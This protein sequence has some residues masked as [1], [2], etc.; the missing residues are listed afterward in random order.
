MINSI[1]GPI[2][3]KEVE[4][5]AFEHVLC[6]TR[7]S[8][9]TLKISLETLGELRRNPAASAA[10]MMLDS[11]VVAA[12][13]LRSMRGLVCDV[14][15]VDEH[16]NVAGLRR[17]A[18]LSGVKIAYGA[19]VS[20][21]ADFETAVATLKSELRTAG[22]ITVHLD[23][24]ALRAANVVSRDTGALV[25]VTLP[26]APDAAT[27]RARAETAVRFFDDPRRL[28]L[29]SPNRFSP[30]L[31]TD[32]A[33][34]LV[35]SFG[36]DDLNPNSLS[37]AVRMRDLPKDVLLSTGVRYKTQLVTY[38]GHGY[39]CALLCPSWTPRVADTHVFSLAT[40]ATKV[41]CLTPP[42]SRLSPFTNR[43]QGKSPRA[44]LTA[45]FRFTALLLMWAIVCITA[46]P[47]R[48]DILDAKMQKDVSIERV[49]DYLSVK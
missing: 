7:N 30:S 41:T 33:V 28:V 22:F 31:L 36:M 12:R 43:P 32:L 34:S 37:D 3:V 23:D 20:R 9:G 10:N 1:S 35:D 18:E 26:E 6:D 13:E 17:V 8:N 38:G 47:Q 27:L 24:V 42:C 46:L 4:A 44:T 14:T 45:I 5:I 16:R 48:S 19:S 11:E 25:V 29:R 39:E 40:S 21:S 2:E 49:L 15:T